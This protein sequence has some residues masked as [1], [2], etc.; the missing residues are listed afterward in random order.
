MTRAM[1]TLATSFQSMC[2]FSLLKEFPVPL[3]GRGLRGPL[4]Y[5]AGEK[6]TANHDSQENQD[7][8]NA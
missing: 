1:A 4:L 3:L 6:H 7:A 8:P 5:P 2:I